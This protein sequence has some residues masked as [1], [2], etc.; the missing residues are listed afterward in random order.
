VE[1]WGQNKISEERG[2]HLLG[3]EAKFCYKN[4]KISRPK[5]YFNHIHSKVCRPNRKTSKVKNEVRN[6]YNNFCEGWIGLMKWYPIIHAAEN[7]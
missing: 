7:L 3:T 1:R 4:D 2:I 6:D 5:A